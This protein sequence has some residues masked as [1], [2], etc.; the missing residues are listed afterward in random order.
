MGFWSAVGFVRSFV[1]FFGI[2]LDL[3]L[4]WKDQLGTT[5]NFLPLVLW[6][7]PNPNILGSAV[8]LIVTCHGYCLC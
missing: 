5:R 8:C 7:P 6:L 1:M 3:V 4:G 2:P